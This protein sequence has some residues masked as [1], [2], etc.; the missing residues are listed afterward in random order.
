MH[1]AQLADL[2]AQLADIL[3]GDEICRNIPIGFRS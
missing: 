1:I 3:T 2:T